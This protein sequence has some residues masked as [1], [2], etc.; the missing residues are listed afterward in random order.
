MTDT[1]SSRRVIVD[2]IDF[3][4]ALLFPRIVGSIAAGLRPGRVLVAFLMLTALSAAGA[5]WDAAMPAAVSPNGLLAGP[6]DERAAKAAQD[7]IRSQVVT[8]LPNERLGGA[9]PEKITA[10]QARRML[11]ASIA[12]GD[13]VAADP[14]A[15]SRM[16][17]AI[18]ASRPRGCFEAFRDAASLQW[19]TLVRSVV[20]LDPMSAGTA[21]GRLLFVIPA[22]LW[23]CSPSFCVVFGLV[24]AAVA[25]MGAGALAR[26]NAFD[27]AEAP[28]P[29]A[30]QALGYARHRLHALAMG[31]VLPMMMALLCMAIATAIGLGMALPVLDVVSSVLAPLALGLSFVAV[32]AVTVVVVGLLLLA[33]AVACDGA[34]AVESAQRAGAYIMAHPMLSIGYACVAIVALSLGTVMVDWAVATSWNWTMDAYAALGESNPVRAAGRLQFL[35]SAAMGTGV[36]NGLSQRI[37]AGTLGFWRTLLCGIESAAI[38][39][40]AVAASTRVYLLL[41]RQADG[42]EPGDIWADRPL[43]GA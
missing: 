8:R 14:E 6:L 2:L 12:A 31:P 43:T 27:L 25:G 41:R 37:S 39:S 3:R 18:E 9:D 22:R 32:L 5:V 26:M 21:I 11:E 17:A 38:I 29:T 42:V 33:P 13:A 35:E 40:M 34:D 28:R 36:G 16:A 7:Q 10:A 1:P 30:M 4:S 20:S 15:V 23:A 24:A 19:F